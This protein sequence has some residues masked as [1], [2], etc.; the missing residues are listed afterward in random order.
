M[1]REENESHKQAA[2]R[3]V[4]KLG[5]WELSDES[6]FPVLAVV[7]MSRV[8]HNFGCSPNPFALPQHL[9]T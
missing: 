3:I 4:S 1:H 2:A 7:C 6:L 9:K 5:L 8:I